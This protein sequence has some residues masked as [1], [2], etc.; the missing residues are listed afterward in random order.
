MHRAPPI[1]TLTYTPC[2][3]TTL[4]RSRQTLLGNVLRQGP[5][6]L[7]FLDQNQVRAELQVTPQ[8]RPLSDFPLIYW[9]QIFVGVSTALVGAWVWSLRRD[10]KSTRLNS[11]H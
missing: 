6:W 11:S 1:S 3:S 2:P 7:E 10:R 5:V 9:V 4:F 8:S